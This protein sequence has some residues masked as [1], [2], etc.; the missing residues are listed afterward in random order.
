MR[1]FRKQ[2]IVLILPVKLFSVLQITWRKV[3]SGLELHVMWWRVW[4]SRDGERERERE[5]ERKLQ[6]KK[7][8]VEVVTAN[9]VN[10]TLNPY[11]DSA[12]NDLKFV[13][14][15]LVS[16]ILLKSILVNGVAST[17]CSIIFTLPK[18][19]AA[20]FNGVCLKFSVIRVG[21][22]KDWEL[23]AS[24]STWLW[25]TTCA[26]VTSFWRSWSQL[27]RHDCIL[28]WLSGVM[29]E[30]E[31]TDKVSSKLFLYWAFSCHPT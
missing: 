20:S 21:L 26:I 2:Y 13:C 28:M 11:L 1:R 24:S 23:C 14:N 5:R 27:R 25:L 22:Q 18:E 8:I 19:W 30:G 10:E 29:S 31:I 6:R 4:L 12:W 15:G 3:S 17:D 16:H 7:N 9:L